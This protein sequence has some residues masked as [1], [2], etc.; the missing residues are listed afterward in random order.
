[1][2]ERD[3]KTELLVGL[4]LT[5]GLLFLGL[6]ILQFSS[7]RELF[8]DT[9]VITVPFPDGSGV[10]QDTP[11]LFGGLK[12]GKV[13]KLPQHDA[14]YTGV[15]IAL[16]IYNTEKIPIDAK[17]GIGTSGLLGD[18]YIEIR[19]SSPD[20]KTYYADGAVV[21]KESV[22][23]S[24]GLGA[25]QDTAKDLGKKVDVAVEDLRAVIADLRTSLKK[26]NEGLLTEKSVADLKSTFTHLNSVTT[27]LDEKTFSE[28]TSADVKAAVAALKETAKTMEAAA[29][30]LDP[31]LTKLDHAAGN[32]EDM[33]VSAD[34]AMKSLEG[35]TTALRK[36]DG[37]LPALI[38]DRNLKE[39]FSML[40]TNLRQRGVLWYKDKAGGD[41]SEAPKPPL[42]KPKR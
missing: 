31:V 3:K 8:K 36:G 35:T 22:A 13:P 38:Y 17:F 23:Q 21:P 2:D 34:K 29:K 7:V 39:E 16:E 12:I 30:K 9:Y 40:I 14:T 19:S 28:E 33:M 32:A 18:S 6:L 24:S 4:F 37:L 15:I 25:L 11:V 10:K 26:I 27:R 1:M 42:L 20:T 41:H 5:I